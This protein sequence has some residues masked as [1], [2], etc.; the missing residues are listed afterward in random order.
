[1]TLPWKQFGPVIASILIII[2]VAVARAYSRTLAALTATM[3]LNIP[4]ALWIVYSAEG[5][6]RAAMADF[7]GSLLI[8]VVGTGIYMLVAW[9]ASRAGLGLVPTITLGYVAWGA[10]WGL[11]L[12]VRAWLRV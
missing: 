5:G 10:T 1:M 11:L 7:T 2:L 9:L 8:G 12:L 3:P 6:D 4:L